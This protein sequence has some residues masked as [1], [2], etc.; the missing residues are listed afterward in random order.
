M[1]SWITDGSWSRRKQLRPAVSLLL[2]ERFQS[3]GS[4]EDKL[5][6]YEESTFTKF[7]KRD[8]RTVEAAWRRM[9]RPLADLSRTMRSPTAVFMEEVSLKHE[10]KASM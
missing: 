3:F 1:S 7:W 8:Y 5:K 6:Q 9:D 10:G 2:G 4:L